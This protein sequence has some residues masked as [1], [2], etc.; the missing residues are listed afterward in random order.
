MSDPFRVVNDLPIACDLA[1]R[2]RAARGAE[3]AASVFASVEETVE[4]ADG[5]AF[6]FPA[7]EAWLHRLTA[8][9]AAERRCCPFFTFEIACAPG[10]GPVWLRLRGADGVKAFIAASFLAPTGDAADTG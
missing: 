10:Q 3:I 1:E 6:R 9:V 4:L 7:D 8:F 2:D 5:Y